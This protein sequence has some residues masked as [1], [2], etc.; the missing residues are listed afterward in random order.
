MDGLPHGGARTVTVSAP[1]KI[2]LSLHVVGR[3]DDGYHLLDGLVVFA[4]IGD[5]LSIVEAPSDRLIVDG[6]LAGGV[7]V[8]G[9]IVARALVLARRIAAEHGLVVPTL[10]IRLTKNLPAAAGIGGGSADA[11]ALLRHLGDRWPALRAPI[12]QAA[13]SLGSDIPMCLAGSPARIFGVG[14]G[15]EPLAAMPPLHLVLVN[16]GVAVSTPAVFSRLRKADNPPPPA[17][18]AAGFDGLAP[19]LRFLVQ[20]RNDLAEPTEN[21]ATVVVEVR[22]LLSDRGAA[23]SRMSG[24]GATVFG[25]FETA[26]AAAS[27]AAAIATEHPDWWVAATRSFGAGNG[28]VSA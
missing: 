13:A 14:D 24:S 16:P 27:A 5:R 20:C 7:P 12:A 1:A 11:A 21:M 19:L 8:E 18:P 23:L 22:A 9:N 2:N 25:V 26:D 28:R 6:P 10:E 4:E 3:R 17:V 15:V